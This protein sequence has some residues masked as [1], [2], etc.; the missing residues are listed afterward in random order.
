MIVLL[1]VN[2]SAEDA[3]VKE[4]A[5]FEGVWSFTLVEVEGVKQ[6]EAPF[7]TNKMIVLKDG[8]YVIVQGPRITHGVIKLDPAPAQGCRSRG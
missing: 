7:A 1:V 6:P 8:R 4:L 2:A 3:A 5:R